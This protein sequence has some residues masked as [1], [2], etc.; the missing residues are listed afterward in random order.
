MG[1]SCS[2]VKDVA[3]RVLPRMRDIHDHT[4]LEAPRDDR[5]PELRQPN[6]GLV[7]E[8]VAEQRRRGRRKAVFACR[9]A[10]IK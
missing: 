1:I 9:H 6:V 7:L 5:L 4:E 10:A 2:D 8:L 3:L